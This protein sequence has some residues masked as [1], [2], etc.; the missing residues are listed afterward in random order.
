MRM[1]ILRAILSLL[2]IVVLN[3]DSKTPDTVKVK[4]GAEVLIAHHLDELHGQKVGLVMNPTARIGDVHVLDT[5][6]SKGVNITAL[7]APEHGFRGNYSDGERIENGI[8]IQSGLPVFS[9]YGDTKK[10]TTSMLSEV[11]IILFDMQDVGARFYTY[12]TTL[13]NVIEAAAEN[14]KEVWIL[15]R[16]N[17][18][19]GN[20]VSGWV[21]ED[22]FESMV[23][24]HPIPIAHGMTLGE[25]ALMGIGEDWYNFSDKASVKVIKMEG[26]KREM[27]WPE[28]GLKWIPPSPNLPTFEHAYVYLGT[29]FFEGVSISEG[30]GTENPFLTIGGPN[31]EIPLQTIN[32]LVQMYH[33]QIDSISFIPRSIPG[34]SLYPKFE[35]KKLNGFTIKTTPEFDKPVEFGL[36]LLHALRVSNPQITQREHLYLLAGTKQ[37]DSYSPE[38]DWG[39]EF[40]A[41]IESRKKYLLY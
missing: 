30:R 37:V 11:D 41:F 16:P 20:Y 5:L 27:R 18:A 39:L 38:F 10:P 2:I 15:D 28:T 21:L 23:G 4:T 25:L 36:S 12:N 29:C 26:W 6:M 9:L 19:G 7:F 13:K 24:S 32:E 33:V 17:P 31:L 3:C 8:D 34:K 1:N 35:G 14:D 22:E 40:Q